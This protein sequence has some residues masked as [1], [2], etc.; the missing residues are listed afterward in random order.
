MS[1]NGNENIKEIMNLSPRE[2]LHLVQTAKISVRENYG[3]YNIYISGISWDV[4]DHGVSRLS[5]F[6]SM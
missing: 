3:A 1:I 6:G 2:F 5:V 4:G